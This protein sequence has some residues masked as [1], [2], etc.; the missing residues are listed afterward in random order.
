MTEPPDAGVEVTTPGGDEYAAIRARLVNAVR[1]ICPRWLSAEAD[2]IV[3]A[4]LVRVLSG[5]RSREGSGPPP[6]S[7]MWKV[8]YS[9]MI[10]EIRRRRRRQEVPLEEPALS[11]LDEHARGV[12]RARRAG[13]GDR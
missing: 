10:D 4:A 11:V 1:R 9:A 13:A 6:A 2:D 7:Y 3:Q 8:A 5:Q 12:C